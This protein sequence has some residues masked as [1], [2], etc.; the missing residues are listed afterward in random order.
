MANDT[1]QQ[2]LAQLRERAQRRA[3]IDQRLTDLYATEDDALRQA[4]ETTE[5][6]GMPAIQIS[7]SQGRLLQMLVRMAGARNVLEIGALGGYSGI[8]L[9]RG[10]PADGRFLSLELS[11]K[12]AE[13]ARASLASAQIAAKTEVRVGPAAET[14]PTLTAEAPFDLIFIDADK[15]GYPVYLDWALR[16][17]RPGGVIV[18]DN[19][20][21]GGGPLAEQLDNDASPE[22]R[23]LAE[24]DRSVA[25]NPRLLSV[26]LPMD[27][28]GMDGFVVSVVQG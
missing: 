28:D 8:W 24:Y 11:E 13:V 27:E 9:A 16:L 15:G 25:S 18:A 26:A 14:L 4:R 1:E 2:E 21:R 17:I 5:A 19:C 10:L 3:W 22:T 20:V 7:P 6:S 23:A 12:H